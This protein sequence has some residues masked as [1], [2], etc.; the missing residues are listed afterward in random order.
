MLDSEDSDKLNG[1]ISAILGIEVLETKG[2]ENRVLPE[3]TTRYS[4]TAN[5]TAPSLQL[6]QVGSILSSYLLLITVRLIEY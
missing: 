2:K 4:N 1:L 6:D 3:L 5:K